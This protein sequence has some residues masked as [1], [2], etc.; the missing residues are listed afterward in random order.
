MSLAPTKKRKRKRSKRK[1]KET[2]TNLV[3]DCICLALAAHR[4]DSIRTIE[5]AQEFRL[6]RAGKTQFKN[7]FQSQILLTFGVGRDSTE[8][9]PSFP[10]THF[11]VS[12]TS[13]TGGA[14]DFTGDGDRR[15]LIPNKMKICE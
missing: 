11:I 13:S 3:E 8:N 15:R 14:D 12:F 7:Y 1:H 5:H 6:F 9:F 4:R 10:T 2:K